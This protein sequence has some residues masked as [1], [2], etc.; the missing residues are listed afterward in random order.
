MRYS[1]LFLPELEDDTINGYLWYEDKANG[2][3]EDFLL[4]FYALSEEIRRNPLIYQIAYKDF[5]RCLLKR[6]P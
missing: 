5:R 2:L 6:F 1:L 4:V 3:G